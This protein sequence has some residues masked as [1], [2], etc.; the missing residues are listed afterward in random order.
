MSWV[1]KFKYTPESSFDINRLLTFLFL[2][3]I[4]MGFLVG[5]TTRYE[6]NSS[7]EELENS[8]IEKLSEPRENGHCAV[9]DISCQNGLFHKGFAMV[10]AGFMLIP[11]TIGLIIGFHLWFLTPLNHIISLLFIAWTFDYL[12]ELGL[13]K[14]IVTK[15]TAKDVDVNEVFE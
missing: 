11:I 14:K 7:F 4:L 3:M 5:S 12:F 1:N 2:I 13:V 9:F 10:L 6:T 15:L 8:L